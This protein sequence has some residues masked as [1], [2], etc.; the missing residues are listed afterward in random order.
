MKKSIALSLISTTF[1]LAAS[2]NVPSS[3]DILKQVEPP[4]VPTKTT[5][6]IEVGGVQ[7]YTPPMKDDKSGKTIFVKS[8]KITGALHMPEEKL[9]ALL[10]PYTNRDLT[11]AQLQ[12]AASVITKAYRENGYFV[13]RAYIPA[14][15]MQEGV[16]QIAVIEGQYGK[17]ILENNSRVKDS[18]V[19]AMLDDASR[20]DNVVSTSTLERSMLIINDTPGAKVVQADVMPGEAVGTSDFAIKTEATPWYD[21]YIL[22]DNYG[23]RYTGKNRLMAGVNLNSLAG[24]GDQ[25]SL[26]GLISNSKDLRNGRVAYSVPLMANGLRGEVGYSKTK[27]E[28]KDLQ[29]TPDNSFNGTASTL[30]AT[31]S[32]PIM[33]TRLETLKVSATLSS[34]DMSEYAFGEISNEKDV[35]S[36][37]LN[38]SHSKDLRVFNT[39][40]KINSSLTY[41]TGNLE[42]NDETAL[43]TDEAGDNTNGNYNKLNASVNAAFLLSQDFSLSTTFALQKTLGG[44]NL[45]GSED[46]SVGGSNGVK[47]FPDAELSAENGYLFN[48]EG[49]YN[50]PT[51]ASYTHKLGL[52]YDAGAVTMS[53]NS[54]ANFTKRT[55]QDVGIGYYASYNT[56]F[57][58]AQVAT[59]VGG[60]DIE[61]EPNDNTRAL[62]Q[63]GWMF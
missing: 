13:A 61:S 51:F 23:S 4:K 1:L 15:S 62:V 40:A 37:A 25:L 43:A 5:P 48:I 21:G 27:Y 20:H 46:F 36:L 42:I 45:D 41:T 54:Q 59:V 16:I 55:L 31:L 12:E 9:L 52:F 19:Q 29:N 3:G 8:F 28:L 14:Q 39:D 26:S 60:E 50:L 57:A 17:F 38:L 44:K 24:L 18:I 63:V 11:F 6:L 22:G 34:K 56:L 30:Y 49:F 47:V 10:A 53:D 32:Y 58:K 35:K 33:R 7:K 2:P